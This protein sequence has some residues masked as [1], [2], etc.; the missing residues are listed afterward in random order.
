MI[1]K[2]SKKKGVRIV[3]TYCAI[4]TPDGDAS[5]FAVEGELWEK[6]GDEEDCAGSFI[7][8]NAT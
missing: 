6:R 1:L 7:S 5:V 3:N 4:L 2:K 8:A